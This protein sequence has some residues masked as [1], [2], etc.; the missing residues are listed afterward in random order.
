VLTTGRWIHVAVV[1]DGGEDGNTNECK[2]YINGRPASMVIPSGNI[3][4]TLYD[5]SDPW[6]L[7]WREETGTQYAL[8]GKIDEFHLYTR[9]LTPSDV[10]ELYFQTEGSILFNGGLAN[11][12][13]KLENTTASVPGGSRQ[14]TICAWLYPIGAGE[15]DQGVV[16]GL[17]ETG[18]GMRLQHA[19]G[20]TLDF[21]A[22]WNTTDGVWSFDVPSGGWRAV[23]ITY[24]NSDPDID[25]IARVNF[26]DV[27]ESQT[28]GPAGQPVAAGLGYCVGN[29]SAQNT[30]WEGRIA[31]LQIFDRILSAAEMDACLRDPGSVKDGLRLW[32]PMTTA[33]DVN[34]R[35]GNA[36]H[37]TGTA[38]ETANGPHYDMRFFFDV[39]NETI[40][41]LAIPSNG[42][43]PALE[44]RGVGTRTKLTADAALSGVTGGARFITTKDYGFVPSQVIEPTVRDLYLF[45]NR[46][47][48]IHPFGDPNELNLGN[49]PVCHAIALDGD[50]PT[51]RGCK[52]FDFR[53]D[54]IS[55][56]NSTT[57]LSARLRMPRVRDNRIS[58][59]W[60]GI[61]AAAP[62]TQVVGNRVASCRDWGLAVAQNAGSVQSEG[63]HFFGMQKA[64]LVESAENFHS[65][66]D[67]FSDAQY[68]LHLTG[69]SHYSRITGGFSQ[70]CSI[71]N[72]DS[73]SDYVSFVNCGVRVA[74]SDDDHPGIVGVEF[75]SRANQFIG[76][77]VYISAFA[78]PNPTYNTVQAGATAFLFT[79]DGHE[80]VSAD[81][82]VKTVVVSP[83]GAGGGSQNDIC[84]RFADGSTGNQIDITIPYGFAHADSRLL[85]IDSGV[86]SGMKYNKITFRG[87][88]LGPA[89]STPANYVDIGTGG[90]DNTNTVTI[91]DSAT[92]SSVTLSSGTPY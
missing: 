43:E 2:I 22:E 4:D 72:I 17:D 54:A 7:G 52:I 48:P 80:T 63:N 23:A 20:T 40:G 61:R 78:Y 16:L 88:D 28:S 25:P 46:G 89:V 11:P 5:A 45:G 53:G 65:T 18:N 51:V 42:D 12:N 84:V 86:Q 3:P 55:V 81:N 66:N 69:Y 13:A 70:K 39:T 21:I 56:S 26:A 92:G 83:T 36:F 10:Q 35:S 91:I 27:T 9:A 68:G 62:D 64:I 79:N 75:A 8:D 77:Y 90:I 41:Q 58:H 33:A 57:E 50:A 85:V 76:G 34:D 73:E 87:R 6:W 31:H 60:T 1:Y 37:A 19:G 44:V 38:L 32:L 59:C 49:N 24:D 15:S 30:T 82:R 67:V 71:R 74:Q 14:V 47:I 29:L